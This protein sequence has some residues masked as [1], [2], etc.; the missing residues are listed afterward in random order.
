MP[1]GCP[2]P[3]NRHSRRSEGPRMPPRQIKSE[4]GVKSCHTHT[5]TRSSAGVD[6]QPDVRPTELLVFCSVQEC[7]TL[8]LIGILFR[9]FNGTRDSNAAFADGKC[10]NRENEEERWQPQTG[11][12]PPEV[13]PLQQTEIIPG[14][15][16]AYFSRAPLI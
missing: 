5:D 16:A 2:W 8:T 11:S 3:V 6:L 14:M 4:G 7:V 12:T 13:E 10:P 15:A 1:R 9:R